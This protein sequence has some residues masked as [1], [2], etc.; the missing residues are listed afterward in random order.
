MRKFL[1]LLLILSITSFFA[2][3]STFNKERRLFKRNADVT[4][5]VSDNTDEYPET[6]QFLIKRDQEDD[7][8]IEDTL[9]QNKPVLMNA[10]VDDETGELVAS[11]QLNTIV[12]KADYKNIAERNGIVEVAFDLVVPAAMQDKDWQIRLTPKFY[13]ETDSLIAEKLYVTGKEF[14]EKQVQGYRKYQK[15]FKSIVPDSADFVRA[16]AS[17]GLL[18]RFIHRNVKRGYMGVT[19]QEAIDHY[20][21]YWLVHANEKKKARL[22]EMF[23]RYVKNPIENEGL[24][25]DTVI[26]GGNGDIECKYVQTLNAAK[27]MKKVRVAFDGGV[28]SWNKEVYRIPFAD[29]LTYYVSSLV[30]FADTNPLYL[31]R[32][33][34]RSVSLSTSAFIDFEAGRWNVDEKISNNTIEISRIKDNFDTIL[35]NEEY[36][37]DSIII[38]ATCS[39]EGSYR[40][41]SLLAKKRGKSVESYFSDYLD[42][43][44]K[45]IRIISKE[46]PED[47]ERLKR[48]ISN[49]TSL[50]DTHKLLSSFDEDDLDKRE[51]LLKKSD[52]YNYLKDSLFPLLRRIDFTFCLS[53]KGMIKDTIHT[54]V[55]DE[56]YMR[57]VKALEEK[58]YRKAMEILAPYRNINSAV[59]YMSLGYNYSALDILRGLRQTPDVKYMTAVVLGRIGEDEEAVES[60]ESAVCEKPSLAFRGRLDPEICSLLAN[61]SDRSSQYKINKNQN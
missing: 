25:L 61:R 21:R 26:I 13:W 9:A 11:D 48:M 59:A 54:T 38:C 56:N 32:I 10:V 16:F 24:R 5:R 23:R 44:E 20:I 49:D 29:T 45:P 60:Y 40:L 55:V 19:E 15:Y 4:A 35:N 2:G 18:D 52:E 28:F 30:Y 14:R 41:N 17:L 12:V 8:F 47:W 3:C 36:I 43:K 53:R 50:R 39:P 33:I 57:G 46:I 51:K 1:A 22:E 7:M 42:S 6:P 27:K 58:D 34:S 31:K 37:A